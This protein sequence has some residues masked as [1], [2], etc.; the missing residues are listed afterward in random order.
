MTR[1]TLT[2]REISNVGGG[3]QKNRGSYSGLNLAMA[4][5][6]NR[7]VL[8]EY[9]KDFVGA[10]P[11]CEAVDKFA[12]ARREFASKHGG[13]LLENGAINFPDADAMKAYL[14][15]VG[16]KPAAVLEHEKKI[17]EISNEWEG[18]TFELELVTV[19]QEDLPKDINDDALT[20]LLPFLE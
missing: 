2:G 18:K 6:K 10:L 8:D 7:R 17:L 11:K 13:Q 16:Q 14:A 3:L 15:E 9:V 1:V 20:F 19:K 4:V 12:A 5:A